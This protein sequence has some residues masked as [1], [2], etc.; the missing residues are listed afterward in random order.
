[1]LWID[2]YE[3][4]KG[5]NAGNF[6]GGGKKLVIHTTEGRTALGAVAAYKKNNSWPHFTISYE[7]KKQIQHLPLNLAARSLQNDT[8]DGYDTNRANAIQ[9]EI[10]GYAN[11]T[12]SWPQSKLDWIAQ[13]FKKIY[14]NYQF[15]LSYPE[16]R[17]GTRRF[18]DKEFVDYSG[19]VGHAHVPD[20]NHWDPGALNVAYIVTQMGVG[21]VPVPPT[22]PKGVPVNTFRKYYQ[23]IGIDNNGNGYTDVVHGMGR[24]PQIALVQANGGFSKNYPDSAPVFWTASY[25]N[26]FVRVTAKNAKP[27][28]KFG[29]NILMGWD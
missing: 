12:S 29:I 26:S 1:M 25:D 15:G 16:F 13:Q 24:D 14:D 3:Q 20:N 5:N 19:I 8:K 22:S 27:G 6:T 28:M 21:T 17:Q 11:E 10:V 9:I 7:E 23:E 2:G 4:I 18:G